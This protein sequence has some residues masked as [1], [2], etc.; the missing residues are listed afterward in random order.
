LKKI[1]TG[2]WSRGTKL[3]GLASKVALN[4][5]STRV[6]TWDDEKTKIQSKIEMAQ[7]MVK[8][9]SEL[10][11]ASMKVGQLL[12]MDMG[13]FL[14]PEV[15]KVLETLHQNATFLPFESIEKILKEELGEKYN[16]FTH[17]SKE[18][19][20]A[21][22]IGQVHSAVLNNQEV[23]LKIQYPGVANSIPSDL[24]L[25][26]FCFT[27]LSKLAGK[28]VELAPFFKEVEEV[29]MRETDYVHERNML[30]KYKNSFKNSEYIIPEVFP[31]FC[32][33]KVLTME[34]IK[35]KTIS[36]WTETSL[37]GE[38][39]TL[40]RDLILLY[41]EEFFKHGLVQ[42]DPNP[43]NFLIT[44]NN[45]IAL[46]DFGAVKEYERD[47]IESYRRI[48]I[49]AFKQDNDLLLKESERCHFIDPREDEE[50]RKLYVEMMAS[51]AAPFRQETPFNFAEKA[52]YEN[53]KKSSWA[54]SK[55][56]KYSPPPKDLL[57]LHRKLGG[58][59]MLIRKLDVSLNLKECWDLVEST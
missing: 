12:S 35:G 13:D 3:I 58:V 1:P 27:N 6:K 37:L 28:D 8:T 53:S 14:P 20:A 4:E 54:L 9:M 55:K 11:G 21:A 43:G 40:A 34:M 49:A 46:L 10:K 25:L 22:S 57:F 5:I 50:V 31:E 39:M 48:L 51:L 16:A 32:T 33:A 24:K 41:L 29:L 36:K 56:S 42:T 23:V 15:V 7:A 38:R 59:F 52:F 45:K 47:F 18:P 30:L 44:E 26:Q 2:V 19:I 17:I